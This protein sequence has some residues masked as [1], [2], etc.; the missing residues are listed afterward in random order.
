MN[1][2]ETWMDRAIE[3]ARKA[4]EEG[5]APAAALIVQD[6]CV[7]ACA[8][9]TKTSEQCGFAHAEINAL[10]QARSKLGRRPKDAVLYA[11]L[12]PCAMCLGAIVFAGIR[13]V[14]FGA[15][16][17]E[18]GATD[19]FRHDPRY[20]RWMPEV[21]GGVRQQECEE[22]KRMPQFRKARSNMRQEP[23]DVEDMHQTRGSPSTT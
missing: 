16:D 1:D 11:T 6:G 20:S 9:N 4:A 13:T 18:G 10:F 22:L 12:E 7:L 15:S 2:H 23:E 3:E 21:I 19:M 5:E 8:H 17:P 14:V